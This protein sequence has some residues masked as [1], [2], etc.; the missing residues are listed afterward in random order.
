MSVTHGT[1][2]PN[3]VGDAH[4]PSAVPLLE[5]MRHPMST[6]RVTA[7]RRFAPLLAVVFLSTAR[8]TFGQARTGQV[9]VFVTADKTPIAGATVASGTSNYTT[10]RG[11]QATLTLPTGRRAFRVTSAGFL[12][13]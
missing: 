1:L 3:D 13:E 10:D 2:A 6:L 12:P 7:V 11:G 4:Q 8:P 9:F 5:P